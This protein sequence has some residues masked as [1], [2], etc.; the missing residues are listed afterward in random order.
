MERSKDSV[1]EEEEAE[2]EFGARRK[3]TN[4][5]TLKQSI[6]QSV[7]RWIKQTINQKLEKLRDT[8]CFYEIYTSVTCIVVT[9]VHRPCRN[10]V[11][12]QSTE[13]LLAVNG[14]AMDASPSFTIVGSTS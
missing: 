12:T 2:T 6:N 7:N 5:Q 1:G 3:E 10:T 13:V 8:K 11:R 4:K 14:D 9:S